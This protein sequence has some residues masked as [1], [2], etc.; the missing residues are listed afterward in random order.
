MF[1]QELNN[2][3]C[4]SYLIADLDAGEAAIIDPIDSNIDRYLAMLAYHNLKLKF[5]ADTHTHADHRSACTAIRRLTNCHVMMH[6]LS[7]QP[8]VDER[9]TDGDDL[10]V[11]SINVKVLHTPGHTPDSVSFYVNEDRILTG[12]VILIQGTGRSDFAGGDAGDQYDS[13]MSKIFTLPDE[14]LLFPGHDYRGNTE[15]TVG[16]EKS[17]NPRI[18]DKTREEYIEI[19]D[20]LNLP[21]PEK[22]QEVLQ[23]NQSE[24]DDDLIKFPMVAELNQVLQMEPAAVKSQIEETGNESVIIDVREKDEFIGEFGH[25]AGSRLVPMGT[26]PNV[27]ED[28]EPLKEKEIILVCRSGAR[29]TTSAAILKGLG[30]HNVKNMKGGML[31]WN[32]LAFPVER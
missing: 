11:G 28:L 31:E 15:S 24:V 4:K 8:S 12:D 14:T 27:I 7:P 13:I 6:E 25:I 9:Y 22:I 21:L 2:I 16:V 18:A 26:I 32:K 23:I 20:N 17:I 1:F 19:M 30:F 10:T 3:H 29:S 5:V